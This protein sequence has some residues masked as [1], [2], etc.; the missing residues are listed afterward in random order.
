MPQHS[1][2][3]LLACAADETMDVIMDNGSADM[4]WGLFFKASFIMLESFLFLLYFNFFFQKH[5]CLKN[6]MLSCDFAKIIFVKLSA[7]L[8]LRHD[9]LSSICLLLTCCCACQLEQ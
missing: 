6:I 3:G 8:C 9:E 2:A 7:N 1:K 4:E 5:D